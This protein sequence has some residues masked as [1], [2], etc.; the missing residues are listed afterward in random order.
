[1]QVVAACVDGRSG[2]D[3]HS[4]LLRRGRAAYARGG[5]R[6]PRLWL[7]G[8]NVQAR[9]PGQLVARDGSARSDAPTVGAAD[10]RSPRRRR[11]LYRAGRQSRHSAARR[12]QAV[13]SPGAQPD[14][15]CHA[16][17]NPQL[18]RRVQSRRRGPRRART[19]PVPRHAPAARWPTRSAS[20]YRFGFDE[21]AVFT[22]EGGSIGA[23]PTMERV[24]GA[25]VVFLGLSLPEHGYHAP[26]RILRVGAGRRRDRCRSLTFSSECAAQ[27]RA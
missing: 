10:I 12:S 1:M 18:H 27:P 15:R 17:T 14:L 23:V 13:V 20:A 19:R 9:S 25:P 11:R 8:R 4:W 22:R 6:V 24:L 7:L 5:A 26:E 3:S 16:R 2:E 21:E